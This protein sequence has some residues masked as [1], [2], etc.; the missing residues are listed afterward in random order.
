MAAHLLVAISSHGYGHLAQVS[1]VINALQE[2]VDHG[3]AQPF[4]LTIRSSLPQRQIAKRVRR[5]FVIDVGSDDFGMVMY[6]ALRVDLVTSLKRYA[7]LHQDWEANVQTL[8]HHLSSL[9]VT[10]VLADAPY[11]TLAAAHIAGIESMGVCS[12]NWADILESCVASQPAALEA[13]GVSPGTLERIL[14]QIRQAYASACIILR[15]EPA[16]PTTALSTMTIDPIVN[17]I[18]TPNRDTLRHIVHDQMRSQ[19]S[20]HL[21]ANEP[22]WM[23]LASMGGIGLQ[24]DPTQWPTTC[25]GRP[26]VYL[27]AQETT[28]ACPHV[29]A[30]DFEDIGFDSL[31]ASC[32]VVLTK[33]GYGMFVEARAC[34]KPLLYLSRDDWP[35]SECLE[36]WAS[37]NAHAIK[38]DAKQLTQERLRLALEQLLRLPALEPIKFNGAHQAAYH[39]AKQLLT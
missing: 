32:D 7:Q 30:L 33:P 3:Q 24:L 26:V 17:G 10:G 23:V 22:C 9:G 20:N 19:M 27:M 5:P 28:P 18:A 8:A 39:V 12:L 29:V 15:P 34:G 21:P 16:L 4:D 11:Q 1:P 36:Q 37:T 6:D 2:M 14:Q 31:M 13:A 35:E 25:L 38:L